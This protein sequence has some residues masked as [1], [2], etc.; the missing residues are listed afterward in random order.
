V[1]A[2]SVISD[3]LIQIVSGKPTPASHYAEDMYG[4]ADIVEWVSREQN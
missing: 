2:T 1:A 4:V 3:T